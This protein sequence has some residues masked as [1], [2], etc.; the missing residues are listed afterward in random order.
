MLERSNIVSTSAFVYRYEKFPLLRFNGRIYNG[1]DRLFKLG[2]AQQTD[3]V[4]FS[5]RV[6]ANEG[7][8]VNIFDSAHW[9]AA[10]SLVPLVNYIRL[11]RSIQR[12]L[13]LDKEQSR[14]VN[15]HIGDARYHLAATMLHLL[16]ARRDVDW[17]LVG[18]IL[19]EDPVTLFSLPISAGRILLRKIS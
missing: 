8:G 17:K 12:E 1:Q 5:S 10:T 6:L 9:G 16:R 2:L 18:S 19:R 4:V 14:R 3:A 15:R 13:V 11:G 7:R